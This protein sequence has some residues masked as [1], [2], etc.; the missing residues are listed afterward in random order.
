MRHAVRD[1]I[2]ECAAGHFGLDTFAVIF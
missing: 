1:R 2:D